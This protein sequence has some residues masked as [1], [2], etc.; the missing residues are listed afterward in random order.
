[1]LVNS[2]DRRLTDP[3]ICWTASMRRKTQPKTL[4]LKH[5]IRFPRQLL[6]FTLSNVQFRILPHTPVYK[7]TDVSYFQLD[8]PN[9][10]INLDSQH[11]REKKQT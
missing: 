3:K 10:F 4:T 9:F 8:F 1:M 11:I 5:A 2:E 6:R 7:M